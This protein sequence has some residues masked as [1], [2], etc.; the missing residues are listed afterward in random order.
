MSK[1]CTMLGALLEVEMSKKCE[2]HFDVKIVKKNDRFGPLLRSD[3]V[4]RGRRKGFLAFPKNDGRRGTFQ[5]DLQRCIS[6]GR[7]G[8]RD[9]FIRDVRRSGR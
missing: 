7:R 9:M 6:R 5:E 2:A 8:T 4:S 3:V 1:K